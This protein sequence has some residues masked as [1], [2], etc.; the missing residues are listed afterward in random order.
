MRSSGTCSGSV[1]R[2]ARRGFDVDRAARGGVGA[3]DRVGRGL[4]RSGGAARFVRAH[5]KSVQRWLDDLQAGG[6]VAHEPERDEQGLWLADADRAAARSVGD[7]GGDAGCA[8]SRARLA[9]QGAYASAQGAVAPSLG[10]IQA[11]SGLARSASRADRCSL[12]KAAR[13][14]A[15]R[16][17]R[18]LPRRGVS[19]R[20]VHDARQRRLQLAQ[21]RFTADEVGTA[22]R[23]AMAMAVS[24]DDRP[25]LKP[26]AP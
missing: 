17:A 16:H 14:V 24:V 3:G 25:G 13:A 5:R 19:G 23:M 6:L 1:T 9:A 20:A 7:R 11:P 15:G 21:L 12:C 10:A 22:T 2:S 18:S 4:A 26:A 8:T